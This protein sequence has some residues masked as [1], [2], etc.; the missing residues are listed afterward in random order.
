VS[1]IEEIEKRYNRRS[2]KEPSAN[3]KTYSSY[4]MKEREDIYGKIL[5]QY[6]ATPSSIHM[7]EIGAGTGANVNFFKKY[8]IEPAYFYANELLSER[9]RILK[10]NHPDI[11]CIEGDARKIALDRRFDVIFQST[12]FT[13]ILDMDFRMEL[14]DK[15][16]KLLKKNGIILWYDF[17]FNNPDNPDVKKVTKKELKKI[18]PAAKSFDFYRVTLAPPIGRRV[19][20]LY[21]ILNLLPF[22]RTHLISVI[23]FS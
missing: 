6:F 15:M 7:L 21:P 22:L 10:V 5:D 13:S 8:G 1:E 12:V 19:G 16:V 17:V 18:F 9:I 3:E 20:K 2:I 11:H 14:A 23:T 4:V